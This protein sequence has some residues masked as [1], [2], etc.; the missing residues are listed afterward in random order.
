MVYDLIGEIH[1]YIGTLE[2][3]LRELN[4]TMKDK[5]HWMPPDNHIAVFLGDY[6]DRSDSCL[7]VLKTARNMVD[8]GIAIALLG[9]H[10]Y[11]A[12][13]YH[14]PIPGGVRYLRKHSEKNR[15]QH[16]ATLDDS[17]FTSVV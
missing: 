15:I 6:I 16:Q 10:E 12:I 4:Y 2:K 1:R 9:N 14:T 11:N 5:Y 17:C 8:D 3:L 13:L 7:A